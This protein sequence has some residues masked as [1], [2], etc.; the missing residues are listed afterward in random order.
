MRAQ[1]L[2]V[3]FAALSGCASLQTQSTA[4]AP[5]SPERPESW[6]N[7]QA[8]VIPPTG[9]WI[10][11]FN[12]PMMTSL[13]E[14]ALAN[15]P[16]LQATYAR[17]EAARAS[18]AATYGRSLPSLSAGGSVSGSSNVI[19]F[20][21][22]PQRSE[23]MNYRI[24]G[25]ASWEPDLW[26]RIAAGI[27]A[28]EADLAA[29]EADFA[30][31]R[32]AYAAR[33]AIAWIQLSD[34][35]RQERLAADTLEAR[36]STLT[37][38]ERRFRNGLV[39]AL[40]VRLA[41]SSVASAEAS[42]L[43]RQQ[44]TGQAKRAMEILL[45]RYPASEIEANQ[46]ELVL[47]AIEGAGDPTNLLA[48]RPDIAAA[49]ARIMAAGFRVDQAR[50]ALRPSIS[51]T[52]QLFSSDNQIGNLFDPAYLAG[53]IASSLTAPIYNGGALKANIEAVEAQARITSANYVSSVLS[54]WKEVED[55]L[56]AD[57]L[58]AEQVEAL[59]RAYEEAQ[60]AEAL[61]QRQYQN[62]LATIFNLI[63]AQTRRINAEAGLLSIRSARAINLVQFHLAL[64]G[65]LPNDQVAMA[66]MS[67][68]TE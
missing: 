15:N 51:L 4:M 12:D 37:L 60:A 6:Q 38:T 39:D 5:P 62:G 52:A 35:V 10:S 8:A 34:A 26:G 16:D 27:S 48:R 20:G 17:V 40:D 7:G 36:N 44:S 11:G 19:E 18:A 32:L 24:N 47:P 68:G 30:A 23:S 3:G 45:G 61:A 64:G 2:L 56:E 29:S 63:D 55:T 21:G 13:I 49:E 31:D 53:Q 14:E 25:N 33:T 65:D 50:L 54:A 57:Q 46:D 59:V 43:S 66:V 41:R 67:E 9:D 1:I 22:E 42:L 28:A 58:L